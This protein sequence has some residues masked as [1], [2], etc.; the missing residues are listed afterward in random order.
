MSLYLNVFSEAAHY[1]SLVPLSNEPTFFAM[2]SF[3]KMGMGE[4]NMPLAALCAVA[5]AML[6]ASFNFA[7]GYGLKWLY[8]KKE[9]PKYLSLAQ[10]E[11]GKKFFAKYG[12]LLLLIS[13]LPILN[14]SVFAAGFLGMRAKIALP[15]VLIGEIA[16]YSWFSF[17]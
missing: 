15:F 17:N 11:N 7:L 9:T 1:A 5:G 3:A 12:F 13:W 10:Y 16:R 6:G 2:Q 14:F 4:F 8:L